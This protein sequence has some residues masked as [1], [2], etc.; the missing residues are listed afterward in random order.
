MFVSVF[1]DKLTLTVSENYDPAFEN[2]ESNQFKQVAKNV[3]EKLHTLL[4][5]LD[6]SALFII[7]VQELE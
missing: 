5:D 1:S 4:S 3:A 2:K 7:T 6:L